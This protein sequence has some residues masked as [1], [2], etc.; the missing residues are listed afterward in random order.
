MSASLTPLLLVTWLTLGLA[1]G[2][3]A[4]VPDYARD[5]TPIVKQHCIICHSGVI[6]DASGQLHMETHADLLRG[7]KSGPTLVKGKSADSLLVKRLEGT[8]LPKMPMQ[9]ALPA[10][11]I[12]LIKA[13]I[14]AGAMET[15]APTPAGSGMVPAPLAPGPTTLPAIAP[16]RSVPAPVD[17]VAFSPDG[18]RVAVGGYKEVR[19]VDAAR[20]TVATWR[21]PLALMRAVAW[22]PDGRLLAAA[23]GLPL[24]SGEVVVFDA[25]TG[26]RLRTL[27]GHTDAINAVAFSPDG[28]LLASG[29]Y[30][31]LAK[32]WDPATGRE[33]RTLK[34]HTEAVFPVAFSPD[35]K[36]LATGGGD[37]T[38]KIWDVLSGRR[39]YTLS[40]P[41]DAVYAVAFHPSGQR[42]AAGG[43]D[44]MIRVFDL[45]ADGGTMVQ[46]LVAH[47]DA[48]LAL[49]FAP[50]GLALWSAGADRLVK[51][52]DLASGRET[53]V[54]EAQPDWPQSIA[55]SPDGRE[56]AVGRL[57]GTAA[58]YATDTKEKRLEPALAGSPPPASAGPAPRPA[59]APRVAD[60]PSKP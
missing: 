59:G 40:D 23:G 1:A 58:L 41:L 4:D 25:A 32:L 29:S 48:V 24:Q 6:A 9:G 16:R 47:D 20:G 30:D 51:R 35:G 2:A 33:V 52:W 36:W 21:G 56:V 53:A 60:R 46:A 15:E 39:L 8:I 49:A 45:T 27:T 44:K 26:E 3:G 19:I 28:S 42:I 43:A 57:D 22:S 38:I 7:G 55:V 37:R 18:R 10:E 11:Q 5:I 34:E 12:A 17:A 14:D 13:W 50:D 54:L 31:R